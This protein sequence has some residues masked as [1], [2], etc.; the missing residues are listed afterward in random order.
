MKDAGIDSTTY[1]VALVAGTDIFGTDEKG[2]VRAGKRY[3]FNV[4]RKVMSFDDFIQARLPAILEFRYKGTKHAAY[5]KPGKVRRVMVVKDPVDGLL[6]FD[7]S[8]AEEH[9][10]GDKWEIF[11]FEK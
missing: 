10:G 7:K 6:L 9:F 3:G 4:T 8:G 2:I 1:D 5:I 11:L